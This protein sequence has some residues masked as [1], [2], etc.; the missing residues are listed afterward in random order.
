M[1]DFSF[2]PDTNLLISSK[3]IEYIF[4]NHTIIVELSSQLFEYH[5]S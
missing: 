4:L 1:R 3:K 5:K 2:I